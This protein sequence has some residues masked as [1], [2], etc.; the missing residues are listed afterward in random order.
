MMSEDTIG[1][2][3]L[4]AAGKAVEAAVR[5]A[6]E[7]LVDREILVQLIALSAIAGEHVLVVGPP[8]TAKSEAVRRVA[9]GLGGTYFE[10][11]LNRFTEPSEIFGPVDLVKLQQGKVETLT[12]GMLPEADIAFLDEVFLG[13]TAILN[14]LLSLLN[15]RTFRRGHSIM[16]VPLRVCV[17]ASNSLPDDVALAAFAD[18]F[19]THVFVAPVSDAELEALLVKG[20][21]TARAEPATATLADLDVLAR[22]R[23]R[24]DLGPI[25]PR[26]AEAVRLLR[27]AGITLT[28]RRIVRA[29]RLLAAAAVLDGRSA[30]TAADLWPLVY[31]VPT[32]AEQEAA[33]DALRDV[34]AESRSPLVD[35]ALDASAGPAA[36]ADKI[37]QAAERLFEESPD[38]AGRARWELRLE[39]VAREIDAAFP[40]DAVPDALRDVRRRIGELLT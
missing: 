25:Q 38:A 28:D 6:S 35:S 36:R 9:R 24:V 11:L 39:G 32:A 23:A 27:R 30:A 33:R 20:A 3:R 21:V 8:G 13:S 14:S 4:N 2:P 37:A 29:Q 40:T 5:E 31:V 18:R 12:A 15:E 16:A 10:Y 17:G 34:L 7:G 1:A 26:V 19:L 22:S